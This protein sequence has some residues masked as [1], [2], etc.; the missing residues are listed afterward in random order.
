MKCA[1]KN[2]GNFSGVMPHTYQ[3]P[4]SGMGRI[5]HS[6]RSR[7]DLNPSVNGHSDSGNCV[8]SNLRLSAWNH[9]L[10]PTVVLSFHLSPSAFS[11]STVL[12]S[13]KLRLAAMVDA[14]EVKN[15]PP[16]TP[17]NTAGD[18]TG[19]M[20]PMGRNSSVIVSFS[21]ANRPK[22]TANTRPTLRPWSWS[23]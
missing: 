9:L 8:E 18:T 4:D 23:R 10:S 11:R 15:V 12:P 21:A 2:S 3:L 17:P 7:A 5:G 6:R 13:Q 16:S 14:S 1:A 19:R 22:Y 20:K